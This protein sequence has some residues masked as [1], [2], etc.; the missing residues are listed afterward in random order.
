VQRVR[1]VAGGQE[2]QV[3]DEIERPS[4]DPGAVGAM[5]D[6]GI[7]PAALEVLVPAV[8]KP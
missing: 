8:P 2:I 1:I 7:E 6:I 3:D 5:L 4:E